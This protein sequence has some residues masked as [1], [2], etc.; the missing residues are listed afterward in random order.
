M[1]R[2]APSIV[3]RERLSVYGQEIACYC[4]WF[5]DGAAAGFAANVGGICH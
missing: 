1:L 2:V 5:G 4:G 3:G